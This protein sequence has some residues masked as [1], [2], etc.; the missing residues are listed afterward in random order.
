MLLDRDGD[1]YI[2]VDDITTLFLASHSDATAA[3]SAEEI[4]GM[5]QAAVLPDSSVPIERL[6]LDDFQRLMLL[7]SL[8]QLS[9]EV[10]KAVRLSS[11]AEAARD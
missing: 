9:G 6:S 1:G 2:D 11:S 7:P 10:H 5:L 4:S 8:G 3:I